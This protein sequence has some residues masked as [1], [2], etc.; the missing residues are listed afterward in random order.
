MLQEFSVKQGY[1]KLH[2]LTLRCSGQ[3]K[4]TLLSAAEF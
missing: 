4:A 2:R 1:D 3:P